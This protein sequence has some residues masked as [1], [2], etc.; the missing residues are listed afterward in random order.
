MSKTKIDWPKRR[1]QME[2]GAVFGLLLVAVGLVGPFASQF[3]MNALSV[4]KWIFAAGALIFTVARAVGAGDRSES[5]RVRRLR[6]LEAWA[7]IA[8]CVAAG[9][10]FYNEHRLADSIFAG[11]LAVIRDTILFTLAGAVIQVIASWM[12]SWR[13]K[14]ESANP[15]GKAKSSDK[16]GK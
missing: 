7:G 15:S 4:Y 13:L 16:S 9:L 6:R 2:A 14:K 11:P 10:W 3:D 8:F 12:I 5:M 1:R